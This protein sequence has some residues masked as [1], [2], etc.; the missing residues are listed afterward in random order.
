MI[1]INNYKNSCIIIFIVIVLCYE[2]IDQSRGAAN[3]LPLDT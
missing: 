2:G 1:M 3:A